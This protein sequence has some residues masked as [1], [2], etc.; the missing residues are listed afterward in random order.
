MYYQI[1]SKTITVFVHVY[2]QAVNISVYSILIIVI[3]LK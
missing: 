3:I 1:F 2:K